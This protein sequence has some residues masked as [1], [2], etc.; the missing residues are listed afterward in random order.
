MPLRRNMT[1]PWNSAPSLYSS[2]PTW[3]VSSNCAI[4]QASHSCNSLLLFFSRTASSDLLKEL[5]DVTSEADDLR[6]QALYECCHFDALLEF[7]M[8]V[9]LKV[10]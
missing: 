4:H 7:G 8:Q 9:A 3:P 10:S 2:S 1:L 6:A 5:F